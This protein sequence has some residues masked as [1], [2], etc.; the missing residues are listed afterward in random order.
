[1]AAFKV[2]NVH[3]VAARLQVH[4]ITVYRLIKGAHLPAFRIGRVWRFNSEEL[5]KWLMVTKRH[6]PTKHYLHKLAAPLA[7]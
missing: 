6:N 7:H 3:D 2:M 4:P 5:D 1:M